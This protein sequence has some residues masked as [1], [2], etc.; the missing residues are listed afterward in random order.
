MQRNLVR[1]LHA[2]AIILLVGGQALASSG[3]VNGSLGFYE[4]EGNYCPSSRTC[5]G[6]KYLQSQYHTTQAIANVKVYVERDSDGAQIG[7]GTTDSGGYF[8]ISWSDPSSSGS[9]AA[10]VAWYGEHKDGRFRIATS[11]GGSWRWWW[12]A[13]LANGGNT[14]LGWGVWGSAGSEHSLSNLY[15]GA[16]RMWANS[17]SQTDRMNAYFSGVQI[18]AFDAA[19]CPTSCA[20]GPSNMI[21]IDSD[22]SAYMPL[23]RVQHEMGHIAS[24]RASR[25]QAWHQLGALDYGYGGSLGWNMTSAEF[26]SVHFEEGVATMLSDVALYYQNATNPHTCLSSSFCSTNSYNIETSSGTTCGP[27]DNRRVLNAVRYLWDNY[28]SNV[29]YSGENLSRGVW[30]VVDTIHA[31]DNGASDRQK[32]E[33]WDST[34]TTLDDKDGRSS[35]DFRENWKTWGTDSTTQLS[36][37]CGSAGD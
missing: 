22:S 35:I 6:A 31:F 19:S 11:D 14:S 9:V 15:S 28:D 29:D 1:G 16:Q 36:N 33:M 26:A 20:N 24:Y 7:Q 17:L 30:E 4:N 23:H 5:T 32:D 12:S 21:I 8:N 25:D 27:D 3:M 2:A 13:T 34:D 10:S 18:R 37:N